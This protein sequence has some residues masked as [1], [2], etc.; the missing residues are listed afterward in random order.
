MDVATLFDRDHL[1]E[2]LVCVEAALRQRAELVYALCL[3]ATTEGKLFEVGLD[4][5]LLIPLKDIES[6]YPRLPKLRSERDWPSY[7]DTL[8]PFFAGY[9]LEFFGSDAVT[10]VDSDVYFWGPVD[11]V[12][13]VMREQQ[14]GL[15]VVDREHD[16]PLPA[17]YY[18]NGFVAMTEGA[19]PFVHWWQER[20]E[21][22]CEWM[23]QGPN[24]EFGGEGYLNAIHHGAFGEARGVK[25]PGLNL[26][27][28]NTR[29]HEVTRSGSELLV[30]GAI[31][32]IC[33]HY[34]G[35]QDHALPFDEEAPGPAYTKELLHR[36]YYEKLRHAAE[37]LERRP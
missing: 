35:F 18:N 9:L 34:R 3:D 33:Y 29:F 23:T 32:L 25:H 31:P 12:A 13:H 36:P 1:V 11:E 7:V 2:G 26:G 28:W 4:Q 10:M 30:D 24:G 8:K 20:C 16:P 5:L 27:P 37:R 14:V 19:L 17:G 22:R 21:E 15:L 6:F